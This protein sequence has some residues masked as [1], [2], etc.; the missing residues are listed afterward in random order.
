MPKKLKAK[1][2]NKPR[3]T[4]RFEQTD[5]NTVNAMLESSIYHYTLKTNDSIV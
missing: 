3:E 4:L 5:T 2:P 1:F